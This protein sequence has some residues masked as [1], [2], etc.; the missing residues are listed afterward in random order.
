[1]STL[2][3]ILI[4]LLTISSIFLCG[5]LVTYVANAEDFQEQNAALKGKLRT[6]KENGKGANKQLAESTAKF[7][8]AEDQLNKRL[9]SLKNEINELKTSVK[10]L[11]R[12]N[13]DLVAEVTSL[14]SSVETSA[15][16][17]ESQTKLFEQA[18]EKLGQLQ[19][20]QI[21]QQKRID[22]T[23]LYLQ[24]KLVFIETLEADKKRLIEE[25]ADL[26][27]SL[28]KFLQA[29]GKVTKKPRTVIKS[30]FKAKPAP[31]ITR[32]IDLKA[33]VTNVDLKNLMASI[34]IGKADGV[35]EGMKLYITRGD[36]FISEILIIEVNTDAAVGIL[37]RTVQQPK[38]GDNASTNLL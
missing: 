17:A 22:E 23:E 30:P 11:K 13:A 2:T 28:N 35:K 21:K 20:D 5:I 36:E 12:E 34:S 4:V 6:A 38:I 18:Q 10:N 37:E 15:Q 1:M 24:E 9:S 3:K 7:R 29:K 25:N 33:L 19:A 16:T 26:H 32:K 8:R 14:A 27:N 31:D